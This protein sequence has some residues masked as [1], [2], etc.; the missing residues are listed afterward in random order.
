MAELRVKYSTS[1]Q[2]GEVTFISAEDREAAEAARDQAYLARDAAQVA[3]GTWTAAT[4][5]EATAETLPVGA[6]ATVTMAGPPDARTVAFGIPTGATG[7]PGDAGAPGAA[8]GPPSLYGTYAARPA[9]NTVPAATIYYASDIPEAYRSNGAAWAVVQSGG[10]EL[11]YA[12]STTDFSTT[13][14]SFVLVPG[15]SVT[16]K[17]GERPVEVTF[18]GVLNPQ[19]AT[20]WVGVSVFVDG[21]EY[22]GTGKTGAGYYLFEHRARTVKVPGLVPGS[23]HVFTARAAARGTTPNGIVYG[24]AGTPS[25]LSVKN[26]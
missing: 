18:Q 9:A 2:P 11:G 26:A 8:G 21:V 17:V 5:T 20:N 14:T 1:S 16:C 25:S 24:S 12:E 23:T 7:A 10:N 3:A 4:I 19:V 6:S 13:S 22:G 15:L